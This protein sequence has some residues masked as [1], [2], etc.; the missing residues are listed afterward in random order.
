MTITELIK[1]WERNINAEFIVPTLE[2]LQRDNIIISK[3]MP[4]VDAVKIL[5]RH[6]KEYK[7]QLKSIK[8]KEKNESTRST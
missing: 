5:K 6:Y 4:L 3:E 1:K 2:Q 7:E 8:I